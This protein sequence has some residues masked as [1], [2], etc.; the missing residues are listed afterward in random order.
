MCICTCYMTNKTKTSGL[1]RCLHVYVHV[2]GLTRQRDAGNIGCV[3]CICTCYRIDKLG[4]H[5]LHMRICICYRTDII[6]R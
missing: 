1:H 3:L 5:R 2:I 4:L 6:K